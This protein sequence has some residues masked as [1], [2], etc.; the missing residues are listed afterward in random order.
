MLSFRIALRYLF[1][2]SRLHAVNYVTA[3]SALAIAVVS[4]A[5]VCVLSV[6]NG[7][8]EM[9][10]EGTEQTDAELLIRS[11]SGKIIDLTEHPQLETLLKE[12]GVKNYSFLLESKGLLRSEEEQWVVD[13]VGIDYYF[14]KVYSMAQQ[15]SSGVVLTK[16]E[17]QFPED[18]AIVPINIG[19][20][21]T[22]SPSGATHSGSAPRVELLFPKRIGLINPMAPS[23]SFSFLSAIV[24]GQYSSMSLETDHTVYA[25]IRALRS[26][27]DYTSNEVSAIAL[28]FR[29]KADLATIKEQLEAGLGDKLRILDR[30]EQHPDLSYLIRMEKVM[31]FLI[32]LFILLLA[33]FNVASSLMMLILEKQEDARIL[34]AL[35]AQPSLVGSI[36][37][38][39]GLLISILGSVFGV[40]LGILVCYLQERFGMITA[41]IGSGTQPLPVDLHWDDLLLTFGSVTLISYLIS[42]YPTSLFLRSMRKRRE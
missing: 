7:Y 27:L 9:I 21:I 19:A 31:T 22:L 13:V 41:G 12:A 37:R 18:S 32:L 2:R 28:H 35:G 29:P 23:S 17:G 42:L 15:I 20:G 38:R 5:L 4:M 3:V 40:S 24:V 14:P 26:A 16:L 36:Y 33:A 11:R 39:V 10:L 25:P 30:E 6:Y 1:S 34:Y 8:V